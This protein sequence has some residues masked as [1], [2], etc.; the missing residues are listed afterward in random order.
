LNKEL[1]TLS[2]TIESHEK[3]LTELINTERVK[4]RQHF[5]KETKKME[6]KLRQVIELSDTKIKEMK[7]RENRLIKDF[8]TEK[9]SLGARF[10]LAARGLVDLKD[11]EHKANIKK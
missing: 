2:L 7:E 6:K 9:E 5:D 4:A 10:L 11:K 3:N 8:E 1:D